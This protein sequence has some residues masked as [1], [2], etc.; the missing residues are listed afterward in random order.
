MGDFVKTVEKMV[1]KNVGN[2]WN[3]S[4]KI[5]RKVGM[6]GF[7]VNFECKNRKNT[8]DLE[9]FCGGI[10]TNGVK[11]FFSIEYYSCNWISTI[12]T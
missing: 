6:R 7:I 8:H 4:G 5:G 12:S 11:K 1:E 9:E 3:G 10:S 2:E